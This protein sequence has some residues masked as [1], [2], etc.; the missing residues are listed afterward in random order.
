MRQ[1]NLNGFAIELFG[2]VDGVLN[3]LAGFARQADDEIAVHA[4]ADFAAVLHEGASHLNGRAFLNVLQDLR[5]AGF[6]AHDEEPCACI[7][8]A[9]KGF[10]IAVNAGRGGPAEFQGLE[11][12]A[13]LEDAI[14]ANVESIVVEE[15]FL[16]LRKIFDGLLHF[17]S[18]VVRRTHAPSVPGN[19]LRP[20]AEGAQRGAA[21][22]GIKRNERVQQKWDVV[23]FDLEVALVNVRGKR[24]G[25]QL[26]GVQL[27][28]LRVVYDPAV[29]AIADTENLAERLAVR[30]FDDGVIELAAGHKFDV[31]AGI[32]CFVGLDVAVGADKGDLEARIG[33]LDLADQLDVALETDGGSEQHQEFVV[34]ADFNGLLPIDLGRASVHQAAARNHAGRVGQPNGIPIGFDL[35]RRGPPRTRSA[36]E[37]LKTRRIQ[38]QSLH[39]IRHSS[40]SVIA[41]E[42]VPPRGRK[43][44][45]QWNCA[46][47]PKVQHLVYRSW[48]YGSKPFSERC[49][50][51]LNGDI[52]H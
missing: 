42:I 52:Q 2:E 40:P 1:G 51:A 11:L 6:K 19:G 15:N 20:H 13:Q 36:I 8:H 7:S 39:H 28:A 9:L 38:Q 44:S 18:N 34:F 4:T 22:G 47:P 17:A 35:A 27:R 33:F 50:R 25:I 24:K 45:Q 29:L 26:G 5:I 37:I 49:F 12:A 21:A 30:V 10:V 31:F 46:E 32:Q 14:L 3:G 23:V 48:R 16:H 43:C 41:R